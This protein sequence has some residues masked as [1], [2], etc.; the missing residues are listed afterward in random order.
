MTEP[1]EIPKT[2]LPVNMPVQRVVA[3]PQVAPSQ[4]HQFGWARVGSDILIQAGYLDL[5]EV[6]H[7]AQQLNDGKP[8]DPLQ[9]F[10]TH[11][12]SLT[13]LIALQLL[14]TVQTIVDELRAENLL[15]TETPKAESK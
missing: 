13:P 6:R 3:N 9:L 14:K 11:R 10:V 2:K 8:S 5:P 15:P 1:P 4:V 7:V 12:L